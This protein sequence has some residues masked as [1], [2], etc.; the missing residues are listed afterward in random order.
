MIASLCRCAALALIGIPATAF[1][2][3]V[4]PSDLPGRERERFIEPPAARAQPRGQ[5]IALPSTVAPAGA[6]SVKLVIR[7]VQI[8]GMTVYSQEILEPL[9]ADLLGREVSLQTVY[10]LA[11]RI[12]ARYGRD[13]YVLS[14]AV[15][16]PQN[17]NAQ[18]ATIRIQVIEGYVDKV[19][20]PE[21]LARYRNFFAAYEAKIVADRPANIRTL[22]RYLLL[23]GDLPGFKVSTKLEAS[24]TQL[25]ASILV[26]EVTEKRLDLQ[27]R[28]DNHGSKARGPGEFL[29]SATVNNIVGMHEAFTATYA[30]SVQLRELQY[31]AANY[32][33]VL[34]SEG[35]TAF[36][37]A[38][39]SWGRPGTREL[40]LLEYKTRAL[41]AET[42]L[43]YPVV[44][45]RE[46]NL[47][48]T[49]LAFVSD[50]DGI[51]FDDP[52][53]PPSTRD[54]LRGARVRADAD[55]AD[56]FRGINQFN[57]TFSQ[58]IDGLGATDAINPLASRAHGR[59]DFSKLEFTYSRLQ[60]LFWNLSTFVSA[61][62]QYA[63]TPLL[64]PELCGYGGRFYC[65]AFDPSELVGDKCWIVL[66]EL[67]LDLPTPPGLFTLAQLYGFADH[68]RLTNIKPD[69]F[70]PDVLE[71]SSV[72]AGIR[73]G[74]PQV[75]TDFY[76]A[77]AIEGR[78]DD[79][80]VFFTLTARN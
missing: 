6:E 56:R 57:V 28:V 70:T 8:V 42:G 12:T 77:K 17:L 46:R 80:R 39:Y 19:V 75:S 3:I 68:G 65:R 64:S 50:A 71:G 43:S 72:G 16:P 74:W 35:L 40:E 41:Y 25:A 53:T 23:L 10:D 14:R 51:I 61:Y 45:S 13:G 60:P 76:V 26:V 9:Y 2:Q 15:V 63:F 73:F 24:K 5:I 7:S 29:A 37:N 79:T 78:R 1:A 22:E 52:N 62:A 36:A 18:G 33:Q 21:K 59:P 49:G 30:G 55:L 38:S 58:G 69:F 20:W 32:R 54:R 4:P 66:G 31:V 27:G 48:L 44:R 34:N 11:Q 47:T 67:R